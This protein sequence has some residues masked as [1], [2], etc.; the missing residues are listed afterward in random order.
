[1]V[2]EL[3]ATGY[4]VAAVRKQRGECW[5]QRWFAFSPGPQPMAWCC[6][7]AEC[8]FPPPLNPSGSALPD[9]LRGVLTPW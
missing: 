4:G 8:L 7:R 9:A 3:E 5:C 6:P 1:M 2:V